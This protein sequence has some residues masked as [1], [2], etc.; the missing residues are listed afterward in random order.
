MPKSTASE[1]KK[2]KTRKIG[3]QKRMG[4]ASLWKR[5][6]SEEHKGS[7]KASRKK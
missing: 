6:K 7:T 1:K 5:K 2:S 4:T 3:D